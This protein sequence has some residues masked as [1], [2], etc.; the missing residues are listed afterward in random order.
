MQYN[1]VIT[2]SCYPDQLRVGDLFME[3]CYPELYQ[4]IIK[5]NGGIIAKDVKT[6]DI[7]HWSGSSAYA[8]LV[9][10]CKSVTDFDR[11]LLGTDLKT[12]SKICEQCTVEFY[13]ST[14]SKL[15]RLFNVRP[16]LTASL[17]AEY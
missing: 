7:S 11:V 9:L 14:L 5:D 13:R 3:D 1:V 12:T 8:P 6:G 17:K 10:R 2:S 15:G 16:T 4:A